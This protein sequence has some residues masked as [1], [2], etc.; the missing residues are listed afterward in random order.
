MI[1][2]DILE[3]SVRCYCFQSVCISLNH[4][5]GVSQRAASSRENCGAWLVDLLVTCGYLSRCNSI[6]M[7]IF[8]PYWLIAHINSSCTRWFQA[9][10]NV[11]PDLG[12]MIQFDLIYVEKNM[13]GIQPPTVRHTASATGGSVTGICWGHQDDFPIES[14]TCSCT[15]AGWKIGD[16]LKSLLNVF[17][18]WGMVNQCFIWGFM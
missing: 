3:F 9:F 18:S 1:F 4:V 13:C 6:L 2:T 11:H 7:G 5:A 15:S 12:E 14:T 8:W 16:C 10:L 17:N